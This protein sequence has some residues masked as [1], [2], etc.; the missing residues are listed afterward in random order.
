MFP[1]SVSS[2]PAF[3]SGA[4]VVVLLGVMLPPANDIILAF[5]S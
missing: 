1:S 5:F 4:V 2:I 3:S